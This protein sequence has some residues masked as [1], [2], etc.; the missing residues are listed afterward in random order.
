MIKCT[1]FCLPFP[2]NKT[3]PS[4]VSVVV[5]GRWTTM[6]AT[7]CILLCLKTLA[8]YEKD[9]SRNREKPN[10]KGERL[11]YRTV[12]SE[13]W[14]TIGV[15][16]SLEKKMIQQVLCV[17]V[18][19]CRVGEYTR[20]STF[21]FRSRTTVCIEQGAYP[22][23]Q[24]PVDIRLR[25]LDRLVN[26]FLRQNGQRCGHVIWLGELELFLQLDLYKKITGINKQRKKI[27]K[28]MDWIGGWPRLLTCTTRD[29]LYWRSCS[30]PNINTDSMPK[31]VV[32]RVGISTTPLGM[33][34]QIK[35]HHEQHPQNRERHLQCAHRKDFKNPRGTDRTSENWCRQGRFRGGDSSSESLSRS[36]ADLFMLSAG[37]KVESYLHENNLEMTAVSL[38][39]SYFY[40]LARWGLEETHSWA[41]PVTVMTFD[42]VLAGSGHVSRRGWKTE[43]IKTPVCARDALISHLQR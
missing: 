33:Y 14:K 9:S 40:T 29:A 19:C 2:V 35:N 28:M 6:H 32:K 13:S 24:L 26:V 34:L 10:H 4:C 43:V 18:N 11:C 30:C 39:N 22:T 1:G 36:S 3:V 15:Y 12:V 20:V 7:V 27:L 42:P 25:F 17:Y 37:W 41:S 16:Q 23:I 31:I 8:E 21:W 38:G 5:E